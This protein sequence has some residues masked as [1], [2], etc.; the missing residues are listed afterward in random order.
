MTVRQILYVMLA[1]CAAEAVT[2]ACLR[3]PALLVFAVATWTVITLAALLG[4]PGGLESAE[5]W[6][7]HHVQTAPGESW[8]DATR[9]ACAEGW[10]PWC[11]ERFDNGSR[12]IHF[13]RRCARR[14]PDTA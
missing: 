10:E 14:T 9:S 4:D 13:K 3:D 2:G 11:V 5:A 6:E 7:Y 12:D 1:V 8:F